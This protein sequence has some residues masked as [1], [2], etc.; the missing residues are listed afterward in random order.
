MPALAFSCSVCLALFASALIAP[1][2]SDFASRFWLFLAA[3]SLQ[4]GTVAVLTSVFHALTPAGWLTAQLAVCALV[5][6]RVRDRWRTWRI[7]R[8][9]GLPYTRNTA[10]LVVFACLAVILACSLITQ[11]VTPIAGFDERMY[12]ASRVLYYIENRSV[13][14]YTTHN[15]RQV[16]FGYGSEIFFLWGVLFTHSELV[17]RLVAWLGYPTACLGLGMLIRELNA[18]RLAAAAGT[19]AFA[20]APLVYET[21]IGA[22]AELW[23]AAYVLGSLCFLARAIRGDDARRNALWSGIFAALAFNVKFTAGA[24]FPALAILL[25]VKF[26]PRNLAYFNRLAAG[27]VAGALMCGLW[28]TLGFNVATHGNPLGSKELRQLGA[29]SLGPRVTA[30]Q[31]ARSALL[32]A[33]LPYIP[34]E[35]ARRAIE[36]AGN[37]MLRLAGLN[38]PLP[39]EN[40]GNHWPGIYR[41][42]VTRWATGYSLAGLLGLPIALAAFAIALVRRRLG[43]TDAVAAANAALFFSIVVF[44]RWMPESRVPERLLPPV[45]AASVAIAAVL[46]AP[47]MMCS[48]GLRIAAVILLAYL[49][50]PALARDVEMSAAAVRDG[51]AAGGDPDEPFDGV[52]DFIR[53]GS[54]ILLA[55]AP[56]V[57]DYALFGPRQGYPDRVWSWGTAPFDPSRLRD[58]LRRHDITHV[59]IQADG[60]QAMIEYLRRM[61]GW[62]QV[63]GGDSGPLL[64]ARADHVNDRAQN[65]GRFLQTSRYPD[66]NPLLRV[67]KSLRGAVGIVPSA[68]GTY[69]RM[70]YMPDWGGFVWLGSGPAEGMRAGVYASRETAARVCFDVTAGYSRMD[71]E[72]SVAFQVNNGAPQLSKFSARGD[73]CYAADLLPG[74]D[75]LQFW[76]M[77]RATVPAQPNGDRRHLIVLL[78]GMRI[79]SR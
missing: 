51:R 60:E 25:L 12:H 54:N 56:D 49:V 33:D 24:L 44:V 68:F 5:G 37:G 40:D 3:V 65:I 19:L 59:V 53:D 15:E 62:W 77:D 50:A 22:K 64:F 35:S 30:T 58:L 75:K 47:R 55:G 78:R 45:I 36:N 31:L 72:R 41:F 70:E 71:L 8:P 21:G 46:L 38:R 34:S 4:I 52:L 17:G 74:Y 32:F 26:G 48:R 10:L 73:V 27:F 20:S 39:L 43:A 18:S 11:I 42:E 7:T 23:L 67:G 28:L 14:P 1:T 13:F 9:R 16:A 2:A 6:Y 57:R 66:T 63:A 69:Y 76:A 79:A 61:P 29:S